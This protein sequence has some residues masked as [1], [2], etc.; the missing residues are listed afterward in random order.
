VLGA[1][2]AIL[3]R[4]LFT[5]AVLL[6]AGLCLAAAAAGPG[7]ADDGARQRLAVLPF[8]IDDNSG[9]VG[10]PDGHDAMLRSVTRLVSDKIAADGLFDVVPEARVAKAIAAVDPGTY[11]R[12]CNG[13]ELDIA[14]R[15]GADR[16]L[17]GWLFKM[18]SLVMSLHVVMKDAATGDV[19]YAK[20]FDFRGDNEKAWKR[21]ADYMV[22]S[23][24]RRKS[25]QTSATN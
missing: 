2:R 24:A 11:L 3:P 1:V 22:R 12:R 19:V 18:S 25:S 13:C 6:V 14:K 23:Y 4:G 20:T 21:A 8:E 17:I 7:R 10:D 15:A 5:G 16:V 9:E